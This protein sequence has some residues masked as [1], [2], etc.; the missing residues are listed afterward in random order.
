M[1]VRSAARPD[2]ERVLAR[3]FVA[4]RID[5]REYRGYVTLLCIGEVSEPLTV[6]FESQRVCILDSGYQ[7]VQHFPDN[8]HHTLL[9]AFDERGELVQWYLDIVGRMGIDE[10]GVP[11]YEDLY[12]DIVISPQGATVLLDVAEL[13]EALQRGAVTQSQYDLAWREASIVLDALEADLFPL[14]WLSDVHRL[15]LAGAFSSG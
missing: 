3:R 5:T 12:L 15:L 8:A 2:W 1:R 9:A 13:D 7:W 10:R 11:W 6:S 4:R 14:L